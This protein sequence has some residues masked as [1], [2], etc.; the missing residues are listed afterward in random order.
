MRQQSIK[1]HSAS[2]D[3]RQDLID[4]INNTAKLADGPVP[5][6]RNL[7]S[8]RGRHAKPSQ[9]TS[10]TRSI[11]ALTLAVSS[12]CVTPAIT[13]NATEPT[14]V[15]RA[16]S[17]IEPSRSTST[18]GVSPDVDASP[19]SKTPTTLDTVDSSPHPTQSDGS[20]VDNGLSPRSG[21]SEPADAA[22][23][24]AELPASGTWGSCQ[25][26]IDVNGVL[27]IHAGTG[28]PVTTNDGDASPWAD[29]A[30]QVTAVHTTGV[31]VL[32]AAASRL[33]QNM[34]NLTDI[35]G[36]AN[37]DTS[38][39]KT[40]H[41]MFSGCRNLADLSPL[42]RWNTTNIQNLGYMFTGCNEITT[43]ESL[44]SWRL[45]KAY[46]LQGMFQDCYELTDI[47]ATANWELGPAVRQTGWM[48]RDCHSLSD[49]SALASW[50]IT[51]IQQTSGMFQSCFNI[52]ST[53]PLKDW[54][55]SEL[56][57]MSYMFYLEKEGVKGKLTDLSGLAGWDVRK[58]VSMTYL[59][60]DQS[61]LQDLSPLEGWDTS[62]V[63]DMNSL[64][65][66]DA[67]INDLSP[68]SGWKTG[69]VTGMDRVFQGCGSVSSLEPLASW[70]TSKV[71]T[72][73]YMF[74]KCG[75]VDSLEPLKNWNVGNVQKM[76]GTFGL[77][78]Q[79]TSLAGLEDWDV[80]SLVYMGDPGVSPGG[81]FSNCVKLTDISAI[82]NWNVSNV[83]VMRDL[84]YNDKVL[85]DI[86]PLSNWKTTSVT[87]IDGLMLACGIRDVNA[88]KNWDTSK[89]WTTW[90]A[91]Y[92]CPNLTNI[93]G[94]SNWNTTSL[95][96]M[97]I[98]FV[99]TPISTLN[100]L[101]NWDVSH[102]TD[103]NEVFLGCSKLTDASALQNWD[104]NA[105]VP[106]RSTGVFKGC[107]S[108]EL[109][110]V[111]TA[112]HNGAWLLGEYANATTPKGWTAYDWAPVNRNLTSSQV[113]AGY[114]GSNT[115]ITDVRVWRL[116]VKYWGTCPWWVDD[117][118]T[119][120][121]ND[122]PGEGV[123]ADVSDSMAPP[124]GN[125]RTSVKRIA[126][127]GKVVMPSLSNKLFMGMENLTDIKGL[128]SWDSSN[129]TEMNLLFLTCKSL[130]D[131]TPIGKWDMSH[132]WSMHHAFQECGSIDSLLP[133]SRW[134]VE[135]VVNMTCIFEGANNLTSLDGLENWDTRSLV[136]ASGLFSAYR[137]ASAVRPSPYPES[138]KINDVSALSNW[139][140]SHVTQAVG[141]LAGSQLD[142]LDD[143]RNWDMSSCTMFNGMFTH[144]P[145]LRDTSAIANWKMN[146]TVLS[147]QDNPTQYMFRDCPNII[148]AGVPAVNHGARYVAPEY[149][150]RNWSDEGLPI[151]PLKNSNGIYPYMTSNDED[152]EFTDNGGVFIPYQPVYIVT[153]DNNDATKP[154]ALPDRQWA[155]VTPTGGQR[156]DV[157]LPVDY[158]GLRTGYHFAGWSTTPDASS[159]VISPDDATWRPSGGLSTG[160]PSKIVLYAVWEA[161]TT[162][163]LPSTG[164]RGLIELVLGFFGT[165]GLVVVTGR[166]R[167]PR[168]GA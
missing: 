55:T 81:T 161:N 145:N 20:D 15:D 149:P 146:E 88:L 17:I 42:S 68:L 90:G 131:L 78:T 13:A 2:Q 1:E 130:R 143:L 8:P 47:S 6:K 156:G 63:I 33:F 117:E 151:T 109:A 32:P 129:A 97:S 133:L 121:I 164:S 56:T 118:G 92:K 77:M 140:M 134:N 162:S 89:V 76:M 80:S 23:P 31:V 135:S 144:S 84:F 19:E 65:M 148:R 62:S 36:L 72:M 30:G 116:G 104:L 153:F 16:S 102:V 9:I 25:W 137:Y 138:G 4:R 141:I 160:D 120:H 86:T 44:A 43:L 167:K 87:S 83:K 136:F 24:K 110:G 34:T 85:T 127:N 115:T 73:M 93:D 57:N 94:I 61:R 111:P 48:F 152:R 107:S 71:K 106:G 119:L 96:H 112:D 82:S 105:I 67:G 125:Q 155:Y 168:H 10:P 52:T 22:S 46:H 45:P 91:F 75:E 123:G 7:F 38:N 157:D 49:I 158:K 163:E 59:F 74:Y 5:A 26:D 139:D 147:S 150:N 60:A 14:I 100:A 18:S 39:A 12:L 108:L 122:V 40:M 103:A 64:F 79:L 3:R 98:M 41:S 154:G 142:D 95:R 35:S 58:V 126:S 159:G 66:N 37:F 53:A 113:K 69:N 29:H 128:E 99:N 27:T 21:S 51:R 70:D 166:T 124:W 54:G 114:T 11:I 101:K 165:V 28:A 132:V 50:R